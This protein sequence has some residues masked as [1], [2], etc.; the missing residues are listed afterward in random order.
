M[1]G[2][3]IKHPTADTKDT[4]SLLLQLR[5]ASYL[6]GIKDP[7][8]S[9]LDRFV[10]LTNKHSPESDAESSPSIR[11]ERLEIDLRRELQKRIESLV[12]DSAS[13]PSSIEA[14]GSFWF[15]S[16]KHCWHC[17]YFGNFS[18]E[19]KSSNGRDYR[20]ID[21]NMVR[22]LPFVLLEDV[23]DGLPVKQAM[24]FWSQHMEQ[25][26]TQHLLFNPL[27][28]TPHEDDTDGGKAVGS[29]AHPCWLPFLRLNNKFLRRLN[30]NSPEWTSRVLRLLARVYPLNEKSATKVWG[31]RNNSSSVLLESMLEDE[32]EFEQQ[33]QTERMGEHPKGP[34]VSSSSSS[35]DFNF[36]RSFWALQEDFRSPYIK[37]LAGFLTRIRTLF[38]ALETASLTAPQSN[39]SDADQSSS[40][41]SQRYMTSSRLLQMQLS[42]PDFCIAVLSQFLIVSHHLAL[43]A[44]AVGSQLVEL[45][46]RA[47]NLVRKIQKHAKLP[48][49]HLSLLENLL[50]T[51]E[52]QWRQW[53]KNR[54][55]PDLD[56]K[57]NKR[58]RVET[59]ETET[60]TVH[61]HLNG[62]G[63]STDG[64]ENAYTHMDLKEDLPAVAQAMYQA[65]PSIDQHLESYVD[66]LDPESGIE[67]EYHPKN[68]AFFA[69]Q[70]VRLLSQRRLCDF[71]RIYPNGD[72]ENLVRYV[73][74]EEKGEEIPGDSPVFEEEDQEEGQE[75]EEAE[76]DAPVVE[77]DDVKKE[78]EDDKDAANGGKDGNRD[79]EMKDAKDATA[80]TD[81]KGMSDDE[82]PADR[83]TFEDAK[84]DGSSSAKSVGASAT[85]SDSTGTHRR[86]KDGKDD[87]RSSDRRDSSGAAGKE[88]SS[89]PPR[90]SGN[91]RRDESP[92]EGSQRSDRGRMRESPP[93]PS[94]DGRRSGGR[95]GSWEDRDRGDERDRRGGPSGRYDDYDDRRSGSGRPPD[96]H[97][98]RRGG[99][100]GRPYHEGDDRR[101]GP[102]G[103][104]DRGGRGGGPPPPR[105]DQRRSGNGGGGGGERWEDRPRGDD[106]RGDW[107]D[108]RD[109]RDSRDRGGRRRN[110]RR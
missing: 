35:K 91:V 26:R 37:N 108:G 94:R 44:P 49:D 57:K 104:G 33:H 34:E 103:G 36:Y 110:T 16:L 1:S 42:D 65:A 68:D 100:G 89:T 23:L 7:F 74:K 24:Q 71:D 67:A 11:S 102:G 51:S 12:D 96:H 60:E 83:A 30:S 5:D 53:K 9:I 101:R 56:Q 72:F 62:H 32:D 43:E 61:K 47:R 95:S 50:D 79:V 28:W 66:A 46:Q 76:A 54:C 70:A 45:R 22:K 2:D 39:P 105:D 20:L 31:S 18:T 80:K 107:R 40:P 55:Q 14:V 4:E 58:G 10:P 106:R 73:H 78:A 90:R 63:N 25:V 77:E 87:R 3:T 88:L 84:K 52:M 19:E 93:P 21:A 15:E 8:K 64:P 98:D 81:M 99:G 75:E 41:L 17:V 27:L 86:E 38:Q 29:S 109:G 92:R 6:D 69:W 97:D 48:T 13:R 59:E 82:K 85:K